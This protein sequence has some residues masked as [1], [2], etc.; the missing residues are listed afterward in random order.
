MSKKEGNF[1]SEEV[2][3]VVREALRL[4]P[5]APFITRS[6]AKPL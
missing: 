4:H 5:S 1:E 3:G 2:T 6:L